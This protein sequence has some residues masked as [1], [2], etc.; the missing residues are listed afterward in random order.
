MPVR[1]TTIS[2]ILAGV[3]Y[4][5]GTEEV[6]ITY[7]LELGSG[8]G[9][10]EGGEEVAV[11]DGS[12]RVKRAAFGP[13]ILSS[14]SG[15]SPTR[16]RAYRFNSCREHLA[17]THIGSAGAPSVLPRFEPNGTSRQCH[18]E[19]TGSGTV[20]IDWAVAIY[21]KFSYK[22][23]EESWISQAPE[24]NEWGTNVHDGRVWRK[25]CYVYHSLWRATYPDRV[26]VLGDWRFG[27][28]AYE[29][30]VKHGG[31]EICFEL[32]GVLPSR[33][34]PSENGERVYYE[35]FH[36]RYDPIGYGGGSCA[37]ENLPI[38]AN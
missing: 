14:S 20:V 25:G 8:E 26:N 17:G 23:G 3:G 15:G 38:K 35:N 32:D 13:P 5:V 24:C 6:T 2:P 16:T 22:W 19:D 18:S 28:A 1:R 34:Q 36:E 30:G 27:T 10:E 9:E 21:G 4:E 7:P 12:W 29:G 33:P 37:W 11:G 31:Q